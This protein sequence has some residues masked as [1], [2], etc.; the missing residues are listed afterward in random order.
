MIVVGMVLLFL[1]FGYILWYCVK[2]EQEESA[3]ITRS[4]TEFDE[5]LPKRKR[6]IKNK[7]VSG[8]RKTSEKLIV[9]APPSFFAED[10]E[11]N[12]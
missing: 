11:L 7:Q 2:Y 10:P 5:V 1:I 12:S 9:E 3:K 8:E 6:T 4:M